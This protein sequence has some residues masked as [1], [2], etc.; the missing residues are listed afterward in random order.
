M[1]PLVDRQAVEKMQE[2]LEDLKEQGGKVIFGGEVLGGGLFDTRDLCEALHLRGRPRHPVVRRETFAPILYLIPYDA[3]KRRSALIM[4]SLRGSPSA[5]FTNDLRESE[6]FLSHAGERL[7]HCQREHRDFGG[8]DRRGLR[9][10][11]GHRRRK[12]SRLGRLEELH[13]PPDQHHQLVGRPAAG[14][15]DSVRN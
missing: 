7:R 1:G 2:A 13:A 4:A 12:R 6:I 5:I 11:K 9:G 3:S 10:R 8:G 14:P 15:R